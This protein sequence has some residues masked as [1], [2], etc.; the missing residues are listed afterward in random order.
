MEEVATE[1]IREFMRV[2]SVNIEPMSNE[3][4]RQQILA[5]GPENEIASAVVS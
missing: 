4:L 2:F 5:G 3:T 1:V